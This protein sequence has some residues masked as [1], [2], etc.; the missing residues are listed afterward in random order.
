MES[1][2]LERNPS[3]VSGFLVYLPYDDGTITKH[4]TKS[5]S[6]TSVVTGC[7]LHGGWFLLEHM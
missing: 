4:R 7:K 2:G 3:C 6:S 1:V 5:C